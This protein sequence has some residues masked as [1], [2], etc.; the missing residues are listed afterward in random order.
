[1]VAGLVGS[2][3]GQAQ[4][5]SKKP[6]GST[7]DRVAV[8]L[9]TLTNSKGMRAEI[10]NFGGV[11]VSLTAPDRAGKFVDVVLGFSDLA[12]YEKAGPYFGALIGRYGNRIGGAQ[13]SLNGSAYKLAANNGANNLHGGVKGFDKRVWQAKE[14]K[15]A[16]GPSIE[17][18]YVSKDGEEGFPG[19]LSAR[20][21]Y[22]L[23]NANE[24]KIEYSATTD[25]TTI[26]NLTSHGYFN[27]AGQG[28]GDILGHQ[29]MINASRYTPVDAALIPTGV[30]APVA[31]TPFDFTKQTAIGARINQDN[32][33]IKLGNGYDHNWVLNRQGVG[34]VKAAEVHEPTSGRVLEVLTTEPGLQFYTANFLDG[35]LEGK[36]G[37]MYQKRSAFCLETQ[38]YPDS[39]N[40]PAFPSVVLKPGETYR[41][42]TVYRFSAK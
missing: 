34:L 31:G 2:A 11:V 42:T 20:V 25:K 41:S 15:S 35:T 14:I 21:V 40:K 37:K 10:T 17:L 3:F 24:L 39:P 32:P 29:L 38:H 16:D 9:Y 18:T 22:T 23:T 30:L 36:E 19:N 13:F 7:Q 6:F 28:Q 27:L 12:S 5:V 26:V 1:M 33:Q 8:D 4:G